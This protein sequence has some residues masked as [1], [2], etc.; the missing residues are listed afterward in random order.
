M[1][2]IEQGIL[3][4]AELGLVALVLAYT[5]SLLQVM[6]F[7]RSL[8]KLHLM[9]PIALGQLFFICISF[10]LL[11]LAFLLNDFSLKYVAQNSNS[12]LPFYYK[13][14]AIWGAHEGS[15]LL[16]ILILG[17]WGAIV[18]VVAKKWEHDFS[19]SLLLVF[20]LIGA[21]FLSILL[22]SSNPYA[23]NF[24]DIPI[25]GADL[26]P[27]LQD[28]AMILHPPILYLGYVGTAV[29]FAFAIAALLNGKLDKTW[30]QRLRPFAITT[31]VF[32]TIGIALG[33]WWAYYELGWGGWWFWDAV[34][35]ASLM[36]W[37][38]TTALIHCLV[39]G[40]R[41]GRLLFVSLILA[42]AGFLL[43]IFGT[44]LVRSGSIISV[45]AFANDPKRGL[46]FLM[47]LALALIV[48]G[49][50]LA[51]RI[52]SLKIRFIKYDRIA[53]FMLINAALLITAIFAVLLGTIFPLLAEFLYGVSIFVGHSYFNLIFIPIM[54]ILFANMVIYF[55][56]N[57]RLLVKILLICF[58][59]SFVLLY[60]IF[61]AV[62]LTSLLGVS[63]ALAMI[64]SSC[65]IKN[66]S[67]N[68]AHVGLA[69]IVLGI[70]ITPAY[71]IEKDIKMQVGES[72]KLANFQIKFA[73]ISM[74]DGANFVGFKG[75]FNL[76]KGNRN[77]I[78][79]PEKRTY[80]FP[81]TQT[82]ETAI[83]KGI[84]Q[85]IYIALGQKISDDIWSVRVYY[86]PFVRCIW[87]GA[88]IMAFSGLYTVIRLIN[89]RLSQPIVASS[90][91]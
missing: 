4:L 37:L 42:I 87:F 8:S 73:G 21:G 46:L 26:N 69:I 55:A 84:L 20:A 29:P 90:K 34:E 18:A 25:D 44:F 89:K 6:S 41:D 33:S 12:A 72:I 56:E 52:K 17:S 78:I 24:I 74:V 32:L 47:L 91:H 58:C 57:K 35:N 14:T 77:K 43:S 31:W 64:F 82:T 68:I 70:S 19:D 85:D 40:S 23:R 22:F 38:S 54:L 11:A 36:P 13:I 61:K 79:Y 86:K 28:W 3:M 16:W 2:I 65:R 49:T 50:L 5:L 88:I 60:L 75:V 10:L 81:Q 15:L 27:M 76:S 59:S 66:I 62:H 39:V 83:A 7:T 63:C 51:Q 80:L 48:T 9:R 71:E 53:I 1:K 45:H 30:A 67:M